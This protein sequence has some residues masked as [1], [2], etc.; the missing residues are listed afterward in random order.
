MNIL[1]YEKEKKLPEII[2]KLPNRKEEELKHYMS[3]NPSLT[4]R[5]NGFGPLN[6]S[7]IEKYCK[8]KR[9]FKYKNLFHDA[10]MKSFS[11]RFLEK[12]GFKI[13]KSQRRKHEAKKKS[14]T[15]KIKKTKNSLKNAIEKLREKI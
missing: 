12:R 5:Q 3:K 14:L 9:C 15:T 6:Q 11:F 1:L 13:P 10:Y 2:F 7:E 4:V 8:D